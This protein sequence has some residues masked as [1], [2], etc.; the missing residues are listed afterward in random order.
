MRRNLKTVPELPC[1]AHLLA[2]AYGTGKDDY[3]A[4]VLGY[5]PSEEGRFEQ[6]VTWIWNSDPCCFGF[7]DGHYMNLEEQLQPNGFDLTLK[8]IS[9]IQSG[10]VIA[11]SNAKRFVLKAALWEKE[12]LL[13]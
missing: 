4:V 11:V 6:Y 10:G 7:G 3:L 2:I 12:G 9:M 13:V 5:I 1:G 8:D